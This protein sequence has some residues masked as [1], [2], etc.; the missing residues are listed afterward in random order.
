MV[1]NSRD[2]IFRHQ[3]GERFQL[4]WR[5]KGLWYLYLLNVLFAGL[6]GVWWR[7]CFMETLARALDLLYLQDQELDPG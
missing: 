7:W 3:D 4:L 2:D 5:G 6:L 1:C